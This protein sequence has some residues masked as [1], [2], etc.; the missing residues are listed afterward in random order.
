MRSRTTTVGNDELYAIPVD[1]FIRSRIEA[2][3]RRN[4]TSYEYDGG[5][6]DDDDLSDQTPENVLG[7]QSLFSNFDA[8]VHAA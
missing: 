1:H 4:F 2:E 7:C 6:G 5:F 8:Q 3:G